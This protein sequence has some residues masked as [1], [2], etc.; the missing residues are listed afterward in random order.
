MRIRFDSFMFP[1]LK[2]WSDVRGLV[3]PCAIFPSLLL[4]SR[5]AMRCT[6]AVTPRPIWKREAV[7]R[8]RE[9][10]QGR[11]EAQ[12]K[13]KIERDR[14]GWRIRMNASSAFHSITEPFC[15]DSALEWSSNEKIAGKTFVVSDDVPYSWTGYKREMAALK[16]H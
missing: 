2:I 11:P 9:R 7:E 10:D 3:T 14:F 5:P 1:F 12:A 16:N 13:Q 6:G 15:F 8:D 4:F